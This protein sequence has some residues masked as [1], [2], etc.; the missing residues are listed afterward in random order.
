R[1]QSSETVGSAGSGP[2]CARGR[3]G[4]THTP[5]RN[6]HCGARRMLERFLSIR[7]GGRPM[8]RFVLGAPL[9]LLAACGSDA[10]STLPPPPPPPSCLTE[11]DGY[12]SSATFRD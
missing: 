10:P 3:A 1:D 8:Y 9:I 12:I 7:Y 11:S 5:L 6:E 4:K 2:A